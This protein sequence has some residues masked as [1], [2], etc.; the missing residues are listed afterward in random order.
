[1]MSDWTILSHRKQ[2]TSF[3][4][5]RCTM[6]FT[7][8]SSQYLILPQQVAA[9]PMIS[10]ACLLGFRM[11]K[12]LV[13]RWVSCVAHKGLWIEFAHVITPRVC[14]AKTQYLQFLS[15]QGH[16][17]Q[18]SLSTYCTFDCT[19]TCTGQYFLLRDTCLSCS[20]ALCT[21]EMCTKSVQ[22][23]VFSDNLLVLKDSVS[24]QVPS[25]L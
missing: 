8:T 12:S 4:E 17:T 5:S 21:H 6:I 10:V 2:A 23:S 14:S 7:C 19:M 22:D 25:H 18:I 13:R 1:M 3:R 11:L 16:I 15:S 9:R 24:R 20:L